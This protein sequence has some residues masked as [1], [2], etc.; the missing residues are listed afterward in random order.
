MNKIYAIKIIRTVDGSKIG[1][2]F[3]K[4]HIY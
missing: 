1:D 2:V 3:K 4:L